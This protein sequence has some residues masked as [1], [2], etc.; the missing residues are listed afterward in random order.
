M[1]VDTNLVCMSVWVG[2]YKYGKGR[3]GGSSIFII[4]LAL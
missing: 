3:A 2:V 4:L 1:F